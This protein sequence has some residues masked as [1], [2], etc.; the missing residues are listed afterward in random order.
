MDACRSPLETEHRVAQ[1]SAA[2]GERLK[3]S[4][5]VEGDSGPQHQM[6]LCDPL[7]APSL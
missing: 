3:V 5:G 2:G 1:Y 4:G 7:N 6:T